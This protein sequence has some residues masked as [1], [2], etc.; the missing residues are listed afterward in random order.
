[1]KVNIL[2]TVYEIIEDEKLIDADGICEIYTKKIRIR[3]INLLL[4]QEAT[5]Q[6]K[7]LRRSEVIRHEIIHAFLY[8]SGLYKLCF[9]EKLVNWIALQLPKII[10]VFL[11][12]DGIFNSTGK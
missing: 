12:V 5:D 9:N 2:G 3:P 4:E 7:K 6:E 10:D 8:E 1:M 11:E